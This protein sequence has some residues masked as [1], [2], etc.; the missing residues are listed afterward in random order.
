MLFTDPDIMVGTNGHP[1]RRAVYREAVARFGLDGI[2]RQRLI[3]AADIVGAG[4]TANDFV[5]RVHLNY[6]LDIAL[7]DLSSD[8]VEA[9]NPHDT[10]HVYLD[11]SEPSP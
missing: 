11:Q 8:E 10:G 9:I 7:F 4:I 5:T 1:Y 3:C 6:L 2:D